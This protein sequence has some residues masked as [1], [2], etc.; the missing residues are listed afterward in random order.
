MSAGCGPVPGGCCSASLWATADARLARP[1][2]RRSAGRP[3]F[4]HAVAPADRH[5]PAGALLG[6]RRARAAQSGGRA[7]AA[8]PS[9]RPRAGAGHRPLSR[10]GP[11][12]VRVVDLGC[13]RVATALLPFA[14][15]LRRNRPIAVHAAIDHTNVVA[16]LARAIVR[17]T[18]TCDTRVVVS[19]HSPLSVSNGLARLRASIVVAVARFAYRLADQVVAVSAGVADDIAAT[20]RLPRS[21]SG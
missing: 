17:L 9:R 5:L 18:G 14:R 6:R 21:V 16:L 7:R 3:A 15:Y 2:R 20:L 11:G 4:G 10:P 19:V 13:R 1:A 8:R 12:G